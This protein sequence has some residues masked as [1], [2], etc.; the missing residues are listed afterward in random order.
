MRLI[1]GRGGCPPSTS[2][3][4]EPVERP[5]RP[6]FDTIQPRPVKDNGPYPQSVVNCL[7]LAIFALL[8][9]NYFTV[10]ASWPQPAAI[11][12]PRRCRTV[13]GMENSSVSIF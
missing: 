7:S 3:G 13:L 12:M 2:S 10:M 1:E 5:N 6:M 4:P 11:S 8:T 9:V